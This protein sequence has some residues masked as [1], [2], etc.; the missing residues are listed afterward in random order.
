MPGFF[1]S[2]SKFSDALGFSSEVF[3]VLFEILGISKI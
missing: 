1:L 3:G 2:K